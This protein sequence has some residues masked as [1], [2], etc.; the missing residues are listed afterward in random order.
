MNKIFKN[1]KVE[2]N[3]SKIKSMLKYG[4]RGIILF[5]KQKILI[6]KYNIKEN[7]PYFKEHISGNGWH[8]V[9]NQTSSSFDF[10]VVRQITDT[11]GLRATAN[12]YAS[13][14]Y[15]GEA[16]KWLL[17]KNNKTKKFSEGLHCEHLIPVSF[18]RKECYELF[19]N[20]K[21]IST[22]SQLA[23]FIVKCQIVCTITNNEKKDLNVFIDNKYPFNKYNFDI[24][25][26]DN[27]KNKIKKTNKLTIKE[28]LNLYD[29]NILFNSIIV[30]LSKITKDE[31]MLALKEAKY[32]LEEEVKKYH[33]LLKDNNLII[34]KKSLHELEKIHY[35]HKP[36]KK[37]YVGNI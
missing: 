29:K 28:I 6:K 14:F 30:G 37:S 26:F 16:I 33:Q 25:Y 36:N 19:F 20:K 31:N 10:G 1:K 13:I 5:Q 18:I 23:K 7:N 12:N 11:I 15:S 2:A 4:A 22:P 3:N 24:F 9:S 21:N 35:Y 34:F 27:E 32:F 8:N 17:D